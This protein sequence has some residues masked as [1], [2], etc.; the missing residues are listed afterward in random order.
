MA[1]I[2]MVLLAGVWLTFACLPCSAAQMLPRDEAK[3]DQSF[4]LFRTQ[5]IAAVKRKDAKFIVS[6][7][8]PN[9]EYGLGGGGGKADFCKNW[10]PSS[11]TSQFWNELSLA[12]SRGGYF[13]KGD[14]GVE[15]VA[16]YPA[17]YP[18]DGEVMELAA[19]VNADEAL[20]E[21]ADETSAVLSKLHYDLVRLPEDKPV[22]AWMKVQADKLVGYVKSN[23]LVRQTD[24]FATFQ[25]IQGRWLM[26]W[27]GTAST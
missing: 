14:H 24:P 18:E 4:L 25:K 1:R 8:A 6:I 15:F 2:F 20:H 9:V 21:K 23:A 12:L 3:K 11:K 22:G 26:T 5:L 7:L 27:F 10:N 16:P 19:V 13:E 17:F